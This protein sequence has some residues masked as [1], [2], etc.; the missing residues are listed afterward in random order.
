MISN[1][2]NSPSSLESHVY[3]PC[4]SLVSISCVPAGLAFS[5]PG[6]NDMEAMEWSFCC[7]HHMGGWCRVGAWGVVG[8]V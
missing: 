8:F 4:K 6:W 1:P 7:A 5:S 2:P 3:M